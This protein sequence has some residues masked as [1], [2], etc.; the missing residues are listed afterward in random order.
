MMKT[1]LEHESFC[2]VSFSRIHGGGLDYFYGASTQRQDQCIELTVK[3]SCTEIDDYGN[4]TP[5]SFGSPL[6]KVRMTNTQFADLITSFNMSGVQATLIAFDHKSVPEYKPTKD[7]SRLSVAKERIQKTVKQ[8]DEAI[9]DKVHVIKDIL[10]KPNI[11]KKDREALLSAVYQ[12]TGEIS[13]RVPFA[14]ECIQEAIDDMSSEA[15]VNLNEK[16]AQK[17]QSAFLAATFTQGEKLLGP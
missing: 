12:I 17:I 11:G 7:D 15:V 9:D 13:N 6:I 2:N 14:L 5:L 8:I 3:Q 4:Q 1:K 16:V 10:N